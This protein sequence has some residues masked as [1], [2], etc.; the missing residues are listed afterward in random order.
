MFW[1]CAVSWL[2]RH[3]GRSLKQLV[4]AYPHQG[5]EADACWNSAH[6]LHL[7]SCTRSSPRGKGMLLNPARVLPTADNPISKCRHPQ[8]PVSSDDSRGC[9]IGR[10]VSA[11]IGNNGSQQFPAVGVTWDDILST[12]PNDDVTAVLISAHWRSIREGQFL[13]PGRRAGIPSHHRPTRGDPTGQSNSWLR[14]HP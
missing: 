3:G 9:Q 12:L 4:S 5:A 2:R 10:S 6:C 14:D 11:A 1:L 8:R 7:Y 13:W